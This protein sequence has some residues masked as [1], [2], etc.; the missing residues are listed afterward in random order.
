MPSLGYLIDAPEAVAARTD[1]RNYNM[2]D[3]IVTEVAVPDD[4]DYDLG[5]CLDQDGVGACVAF[6]A[7]AIRMGQELVDEGTFEFNT[8][9]AFTAYSWLKK[10]HGAYPGDGVDAEGSYP[11]AMWQMA[12]VEGVPGIDG[13]ARKIESYWQLQGT[14][15]SAAWIET[16]LQVLTQFGPVSVATPW[17]G[18]WWGCG[19]S[20]ILPFP[21]GLAGAHMYVKKGHTLVGPKGALAAGM[22]PSGRY[23][24]MRQSWGDAAYTRRDRYG[25][26]GE[27]LLPFEAEAAYPN[28][29]GGN[30]EIWKT[31]DITG[32]DPTPGGDMVPAK[33]KTAR[34]LS[35]PAGTQLYAL[36]TGAPLVK[37]AATSRL[38]SPFAYSLT[39]YAVIVTTSGVQQLV[40][41]NKAGTALLATSALS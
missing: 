15:G 41:V 13:N 19:P 28:A 3:L 17:P 23:W 8:D 36:E 5:P 7:T 6:A 40:R 21:A 9:S 25:R 18:N 20:G 11:S 4:L 12:K 30:G 33:D 14:P 24:R 39:Q 2:A 27:W 34:L 35:V 22:S 31:I 37:V 26:A 32:D 10:G 29:F 16:Q 38:L 1:P